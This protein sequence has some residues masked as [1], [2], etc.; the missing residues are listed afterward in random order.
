MQHSINIIFPQERKRLIILAAKQ[1]YK[2]PTIP[3]KTHG[4]G[5]GM[6]PTVTVQ[7]VLQDLEKIEP[8]G[9]GRIKLNKKTLEGHFIDGTHR[10]DSNDD[11]IRSYSEHPL[12]PA[13][14]TAK[15]I[16]KKN[17]I[18]HYNQVSLVWLTPLFY[19]FHHFSPNP[20]SCSTL[21]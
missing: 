19:L 13:H 10:G 3:R 21:P 1:G 15:T 2:L 18:V 20:F 11:D 9:S 6:L 16:I 8:N 14:A 4:D 5:E 12:P 7:D 17:K